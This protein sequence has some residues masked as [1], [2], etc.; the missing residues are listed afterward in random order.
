MWEEFREGDIICDLHK[1]EEIRGAHAEG[2]F[3]LSLEW[4][5]YGDNKKGFLGRLK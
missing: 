5:Q 4:L 1:W 3:V 2:A